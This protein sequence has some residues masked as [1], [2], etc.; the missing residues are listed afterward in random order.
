MEDHLDT[1]LDVT[2]Q[3]VLDV[4]CGAGWLVRRLNDRGV[5][6]VGVECGEE[7]LRRAVAADN[8]HPERYVEGVGQDL[9]FDAASFDAAVFS[10]SLHHVPAESMRQAVAEAARVVR[11]AGALYVIEPVAQGL[12]H[13]VDVLVDDETLVRALAQAAVDEVASNYFTE[14]EPQHLTM[15]TPYDDFA[16]YESQLVG[17]DPNRAATF[18]SCKAQVEQMFYENASEHH[19]RWWFEDHLLIR[20]FSRD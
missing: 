11:S 8:E 5:D 7:M 16:D 19:G 18:A 10:F 13:D 6:A 1:T 17:I 20:S 4:G 3:R 15:G 14:S 2:A 9:P 12:G